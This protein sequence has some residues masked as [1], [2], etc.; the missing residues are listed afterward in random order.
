MHGC[1]ILPEST[2]TIKGQISLRPDILITAAD[3]A[4]VVIEAEYMP[5]YTVEDDV[6]SRLGLRLA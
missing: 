3:R 1:D 6:L 4:P 2:G 5:A